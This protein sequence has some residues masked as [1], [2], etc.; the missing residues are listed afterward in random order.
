[1]PFVTKYFVS[2]ICEIFR[3]NFSFSVYWNVLL[4]LK[5][6]IRTIAILGDWNMSFSVNYH[7]SVLRRLKCAI[8]VRSKCA[9]LGRSKC[10][11]FGRSKCAI[12]G[13]SKC[14]IFGQS[15]YLLFG[16]LKCEFRNSGFRIAIYNVFRILF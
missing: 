3:R 5:C 9:I 11:I 12:F 14:V 2:G 15:K 4:P 1:M 8:F 16:W 13:R 6:A 10:E 7:T